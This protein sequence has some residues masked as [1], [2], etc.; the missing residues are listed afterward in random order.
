MRHGGADGMRG[1]EGAGGWGDAADPEHAAPAVG[2]FS[3]VGRQREL[4][5]V[6]TALRRPPAIVLVE[7]EAGIGKSRL[8]REAAA[9]LARQGRH[10]LTGY[11]HPLREP[12]PYGPVIDAL[13]KAGPLLP[14]PAAIPR[15]AGALA[16]LLP[17]L[18]D[19][20]P[21]PPPDVPSEGGRHRLLR[22][23]RSLLTA[24]GPVVLAV[25]DLH[26]ADEVTRE[27]LLL[28]TRDMPGQLGLV[29]TYRG[30]DVG[31]G[32][33]LGSAYRRQPGTSGAAVH[34]GPISEQDVAALMAE[35]LGGDLDP[36]LVQALHSRSAGLPLVVEEDLLTLRE[37]RQHGPGAG[38]AG[39]TGDAG[40]IGDVEGG[41][42]GAGGVGGV[43]AAGVGHPDLVSGLGRAEIPHTLR[44]AFTERLEALSAAGRAVVEAAAVLAVPS[45][46]DVLTRVSGLE[47]DAG[48]RGIIE[49]LN[50]SVLR[51]TGSGEYA[52]RHVLAQQAAYRDIPGPQRRL[53]HRQAIEVLQARTPPPLV[54]I[55]HH[56][57]RA[58]DHAAWP[59]RAE[60]AVDQ[61]VSRGDDGTA[62]AL[63]HQ[64][65]KR[66]GL[67]EQAR[68]RAALALARIALRGTDYTANAS[69]LRRILADPGLDP[70]ARGEIRLSLGLLRVNHLGDRDGYADVE[71]SAR[72]LTARPALA[73]RAMIALAMNEQ[74]GASDHA[75][76]WLRKAE[77]TLADNPDPAMRAT[78]EVTRLTLMARDGD[79]AVWPAVDRLPRR[80]ADADLIRQT[81]RA[82]YN[83]GEI[84]IELGHD[85]RARAMLAEG[86]EL[87]QQVSFPWLEC[88]I[89]IAQLRLQALGGDWA[90]AE[91]EFTQ[92]VRRFPDIVMAPSE[93]ALM[94][95]RIALAKGH[96][97][98]ALE[99]Y[100]VAADFGAAESQV[101]T[102]L[103]A[104]AGL[105]ALRLEE[106]AVTDA[107]GTAEPAVAVLR[108]AGAWARGT[109]LVP[110]AVRAALA[111]GRREAA[112][113]L[114]ADVA[115]GLE[116][117][118][119][120]A[121]D[122]ELRLARGHLGTEPKA[123][124]EQ[125]EQARSLWLEIGR[126]Y[127][128]AQ[129]AECMG[130]ALADV[131]PDRAG[132]WLREAAGTYRELG[133][134][135]DAARCGH[136]VKELGLEPPASR[137]RRGYGNALSPRERQVAEFVAR[138]ATNHEIA[139]AL[140][141][142]PR[143][144]ELHVA[145]ALRKLR[146]TR[147]NV[148]AALEAEQ[149]RAS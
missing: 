121:A 54:Q 5:L 147:K 108:R 6:V 18:A 23:V 128:A 105:T 44:E 22:G 122:A 65:L 7:G 9:V 117:R 48:R 81:I 60:A 139:Q 99:L 69:V 107:W 64:M 129:A 55:A 41:V 67:P 145:H 91:K 120:P 46:E 78:A 142:S 42:D 14:D 77:Q 103:R 148:G 86:R 132:E 83:V 10:T 131:D 94:A 32:T 138:G 50:G 114:V 53:L 40:D 66:P 57:L 137:G 39:E 135:H 20:L 127:D 24:I 88:Y 111:A 112:E 52:F 123:A 85:R 72:E 80:E 84:A 125:F 113:R 36:A 2:M 21:P 17:D 4:S 71:R 136:A 133:A 73:A 19:R 98:R 49:A 38:D 47:P 70:T 1:A 74:D 51:E 37:H 89:R 97:P 124:A 146:T 101:T 90:P 95:G 45:G 115:A 134:S 76:E 109:G 25:E 75:W 63:L 140:C 92:L 106:C 33:L 149:L 58:G 3:C 35:A 13:S 82:L 87:I 30:E 26:W 11:C 34:L 116:G 93:Q 141:L 102:A 62:A 61:A 126:P 119:A 43:V 96:R 27:L 104:A 15:S 110:V 29:L 12:V 100:T 79:P 59:A 28:L 118:D 68:T 143:T 144:V 16:P 56:T 8:V 130:T 31:P